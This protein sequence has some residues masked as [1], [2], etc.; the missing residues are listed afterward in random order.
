M[1]QCIEN[2]KKAR[3]KLFRRFVVTEGLFRNSGDICP[4]PDILELCEKYKFRLILDDSYGFGVLGHTGRGTPEHFSVAQDR[5][6]IYIGSLSTSLGAVGGFC[7]GTNNVVDHQRLGATGYV[8]SASLPPY[9]TCSASKALHLIDEE[10]QRVRRLQHNAKVFR[11]FFSDPTKLPRGVVM[12]PCLNDVSP[13]IHF[14]TTAGAASGTFEPQEDKCF[15][16]AAHIL[17]HRHSILGCR[18]F[19]NG[20]EKVKFPASL[21]LTLRSELTEKQVLDACQ[22]ISEALFEGFA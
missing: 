21:R 1:N 13:L 14:V 8:Y 20:E 17:A 2:D 16:T 19:Y 11:K 7:A 12:R 6:A 5:I 9:V 15:E 3:R 10:P 4:L 18:A 22:S